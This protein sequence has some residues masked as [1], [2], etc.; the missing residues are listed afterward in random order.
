MAIPVMRTSDLGPEPKAPPVKRAAARPQ[1]RVV[2][3]GERS[4]VEVVN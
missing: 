3:G 2:R 4:S 1:V